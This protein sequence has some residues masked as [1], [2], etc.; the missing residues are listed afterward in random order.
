MNTHSLRRAGLALSVAL[1]PAALRAA[2]L[3]ASGPVVGA[4]IGAGFGQPF[5]DLGTTFVGQV[6]FG[7]VLDL[8]E[9]IGRSLQPFLAG[10]YAGPGTTGKASE[11][12]PRL[13]ADAGVKYDATVRQGTIDVGTLY[14]LPL[15][16]AFRPY[17]SLGCRVVLVRTLL[18]AGAGGVEFPDREETGTHVGLVG[19]LGLDWLLGPGAVNGELQ[20]GYVGDTGGRIRDA[21]LGTMNLLVGYRLF[22]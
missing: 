19:G 8:P 22:L 4:R 1:A 17:A 5:G 12:D 7:W 11:P 6:E 13:P 18:T 20:A 15:D 3:E 10:S 16:G 21:N 2:P 9:P 14:R